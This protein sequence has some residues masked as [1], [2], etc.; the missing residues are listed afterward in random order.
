MGVSCIYG[1]MYT[2]V[3]MDGACTH[4]GNFSIHIEE[5]ENG[6]DMQNKHWLFKR[7]LCL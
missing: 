5:V 7:Q 2:H 3:Y 6:T 1:H 4:D